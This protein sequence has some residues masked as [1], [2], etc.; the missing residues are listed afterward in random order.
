[1]LEPPELQLGSG[2]AVRLKPFDPAADVAC[3][4]AIVGALERGLDPEQAEA[5]GFIVMACRRIASW[6][7]VDGAC[8]PANILLVMRQVPGLLA[9]F[10]MEYL[11]WSASWSA[12]GNGSAT[13]PSGTSARDQPTAAAA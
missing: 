5:E 11:R 2:V 12:E 4:R 8:T 3:H 1:M 7:G 10:R 9:A 6:E 13:S